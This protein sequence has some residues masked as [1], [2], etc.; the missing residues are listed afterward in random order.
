MFELAAFDFDG[1]LTRRD[2]FIDFARWS[3]GWP[4][5]AVAL[6]CSLPAIAR[7]KLG[8]LD[9]GKAKETLFGHLFAGMPAEEFDR[10]GRDYAR[11]IRQIT[12]PE[13]VGRMGAL[14]VEGT[15]ACIVTASLRNWVEPWAKSM[16]V[17]KVIATEAE[18]GPDGRLT[19]RFATPNCRGPEKV[20]RLK[21]AYPDLN[22][23]RLIA[24]GDSSGDN[25]LLAFAGS[26][27]RI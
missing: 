6:M 12:R 26:G 8:R 21:E 10:L 19:G 11:R 14:M 18:V 22:P 17:G 13:I 9:S 15:P 16:G 7:W 23:A 24:Y 25:E 2:T 20:R 1:T 5:L 3:V 4:R 27:V